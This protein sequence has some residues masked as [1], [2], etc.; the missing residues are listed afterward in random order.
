MSAI[1]S[2]NSAHVVILSTS[3]GL[4]GADKQ[5]ANLARELVARGFDVEVI[6]LVPLGEI[7]KRLGE[8]GVKVSSL[9]LTKRRLGLRTV[10]E[11]T[12][13]LRRRPP[14]LLITFMFHAN[15]LGRLI[16]LLAGIPRVV[17]SIRNER[18]GS[19]RREFLERILQP[20]CDVIVANSRLAG[21]GLVKRRIVS[22][23]RLRIIPNGIAIDRCPVRASVMETRG[24]LGLGALPF[25]WVAVGRL[26]LQKDYRTLIDAVAN[27]GDIGIPYVVLIAGQDAGLESAL[28]ERV[29]ELGLM[30]KIQF[31][32]PRKDVEKLLSI[33][34]AFVSSS[35]WEG[36]PNAVMEA[37]ASGVPVVATRVGG[38]PELI[39]DGHS[40][41]LV[42]AG[43]PVGLSKA[44]S[45]L[46]SLPAE[47]RITMGK[48]GRDHVLS[49]FGIQAVVDRWEELFEEVG[50]TGQ[51]DP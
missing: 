9:D 39:E 38:V 26:H 34:N 37:L 36:L 33:A 47:T 21:E 17:V 16:A 49:N 51:G 31:L 4:G 18:F 5:V 10:W 7:G 23:N 50:L 2:D 15:V 44:M 25:V 46:M 40:G 42:Q 20:F 24:S 29:Q 6:A 8:G 19:K 48:S 43:D 14:G 3:M 1:V 41:F 45:R 35:A 27:L 22:R 30:E 28:K 13:A 12:L 11:L 32:G